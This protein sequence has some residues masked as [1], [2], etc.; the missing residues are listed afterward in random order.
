MK[1]TTFRRFAS[2]WNVPYRFPPF[3]HKI[4]IQII[5]CVFV[6]V[7]ELEKKYSSSIRRCQGRTNWHI[8]FGAMHLC[9]GTNLAMYRSDGAFLLIL[10]IMASDFSE[11]RDRTKINYLSFRRVANA[12]RYPC[13]SCNATRGTNCFMTTLPERIVYLWVHNSVL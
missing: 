9:V 4:H 7:L 12:A 13:G 10:E 8:R 11:Q 6:L 3:V 2:T 1:F 5:V